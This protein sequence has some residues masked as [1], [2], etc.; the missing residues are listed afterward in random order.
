MSQVGRISGPLLQENLIR[1][2]IDLSFETDLIYLD[3]S[4]GRVGVKTN[5]PSNELQNSQTTRSTNLIV[6]TEANF[7]ILNFTN[8]TVQPFGGTN[9]IVLDARHNITAN[10]VKTDNLLIDDDRI[11][12]Y[13]T[14]TNIELRPNGTGI[15]EFNNLWV[16]NNLNVTGDVRLD[17]D[18]TFG[19]A[20]T[21]SI[22]FDADVTSN[23][24]PDADVT[25]NLGTP[26]KRWQTIEARLLNGQ[27]ID[28]QV[29]L[30]GNVNIGTRPGNLYYVST[31]GDNA[32]VGDHPQ[33]PFLTIAH[34]ASQASAGDTIHIAPGEYEE[35]CPITVP[36]GVTITGLDLR[37]T[38][39]KPTQATN[40]NNIFLLN[41][42]SSVT[43][44]TIKDFYTG[45][46]FSFAPN[47]TV[48]SRS[49]YVQNITVLTRG[50]VTSASDPRGFAQGDAGKGA[51]VDGASVLSTSKD[52]SMLFHAVTFITPG[53]DALTMTNG[54]KVEWLNSFTYF[55]NRG[56]YAV[57][58]STGHLSTDGSTVDYGA[59]IRSIGSANVYGNYGAVAD[60]SDTLMYLIQHNMAY[61]GVG[62]YSD[63]DPSRVIQSQEISK[64]NSGN[65]YYQTVNHAGNFR[66]GD[67]F[68]INQDTGESSI[69]INEGQVQG[70]GRLRAT[71]NGNVTII[72][73]EE[74]S[75]GNLLF[76]QN[77][78][79]SVIGDINVD[80]FGGDINLL[81]NT[82][83]TGDVDITG[84]LTFDGQL[85]LMGNQASDT[86]KFN[87]NFDQDI[88]PNITS[89]YD[90]GSLNK[91]WNGIWLTEAQIDDIHIEDNFITTDSSNADLDLRA[92]GTGDI[93]IPNN[94]VQVDNNL[95][96]SGDTDLQSLDVTGNIQLVGD[97]NTTGNIS[98]TNL[99]LDGNLVS[100]SQ[101]QLEEI[102]VDGNVI[103]TT[104]LNADLELRAA[105]T[106]T[107]NTSEQ[108]QINN[109]LSLSDLSAP[110]SIIT[111]TDNVRFDTAN[112]TNVV[113]QGNK[114]THKPS[115][116]NDYLRLMNVTNI[117]AD[118]IVQNNV[119][120]NGTTDIDNVTVNG[121]ITQTGNKTQT[122]NYTLAG[123]F[124]N[125]NLYI[126]DN[127]ITTTESNSDLELRANG[128]GDI[129]I[130]TD[131]TVT[132][133]NNL[134]VGGV[135]QY[136]GFLQINGDVTLQGNIQDG[137]LT[138]TE[139]FNVTGNL[140]VT[141]NAQL[142]EILIDDNFITTTTSNADLELRA[143]GTG[144][145]LF[146]E[147]TVIP[148][149]M[150]SPSMDTNNIVNSQIITSNKFSTTDNNITIDDNFITTE[151]S[152]SNL[153]L[154]A[155]GNVVSQENTIIN[156]NL[157]VNGDTDLQDTTITGT[158]TY[159]GDN[160]QT[161]NL[162]LTGDINLSGN[163][164]ITNQPFLFED[165]LI[166][167]NVLTT[168]LSNSNLSLESNGTGTVNFDSNVNVTN[169]LTARDITV[170]DIVIN[171]E[172][173]LEN[174][175]SATDVQLFDNV[176]TTS[177]SNSNL[178]LRA[179]GTGFVELQNIKFNENVIST[180]DSTI[181]LN[182]TNIDIQSNSSLQ[183]P[184]GDISQRIQR[185]ADEIIDGGDADDI[186]ITVY[187]GG[188]ATTIFGP[189]DLILD[190]GVA[191]VPSGN[192]G[193]IRYNSQLGLFEGFSQDLQYFGGV[194]SANSRTN[195][196]TTT[197]NTVEFNVNN[198]LVGTLT[199]TELSMTGLDVDAISI[200][201]NNIAISGANDLTLS[202]PGT[203]ITI[204]NGLK[205]DN[206][207]ILNES[208]TGLVIGQTGFGYTKINSTTG[209]VTPVGDE[210]NKGA[211]PQ[212]G[213][214]RW[215]TALE[216]QEVYNGTEWI[217]A[218]GIVDNV[219]ASE[220]E[221]IIDFWTLVLG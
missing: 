174:M 24:I 101:V 137:N 207:I 103:T 219:N 19:N 152:N 6:D 127:F 183:I 186:L 80:A 48:T 87:V 36:Q 79:S 50:S 38:I 218:R 135:L 66:I 167:G 121:N 191:P 209:V 171:D 178:E 62:K 69:V 184:V 2:G 100:G 111:V 195:V 188:D 77:T 112:I 102:L 99:N 141:G 98:I 12:T 5:S 35:I 214:I 23:I 44:L 196:S 96:V 138:I 55:A 199:S 25:Y 165:I 154:R 93:L 81:D 187:D 198:S 148:N 133:S 27:D 31:N 39:V 136:N 115:V 220:F 18:V 120:V 17:G 113:I 190:A 206:N 144:D 159:V 217:A 143:N 142:E 54:V 114:I 104:T 26:G 200:R 34:A 91:K 43:N 52:A 40:A 134:T 193:D 150:S 162:N 58:G 45:Y 140:D 109:N 68:F 160:N 158:I 146:T 14:D 41:G 64:L 95:T 13:T 63:N 117:S 132:I 179:A 73:G 110:N 57:N 90:L 201:N 59:E 108:V 107:I 94:N 126:E 124:S 221:E 51:L 76:N 128:T 175:V 192:L 15:T 61:V 182:T 208:A 75:T 30:I 118:T 49:P 119:I 205:F 89:S 155:T 83:V 211:T 47:A 166:D 216:I 164:S 78:I 9:N 204:P 161:G 97:K 4:S 20:D 116:G 147:N 32:N 67:N 7:P 163:F 122:G 189:N 153:E 86:L 74:V 3:V 213:E 65:I 176:I 70:F 177:N 56:L 33:G 181:I 173:A 139:D 21:D 212:Q 82:N 85:N 170:T 185:L 157:T 37:N 105:G 16:E 156:Q 131:D 42:E 71:T 210:T 215:N 180:T 60:G 22:T 92:N 125:S 53:V 149:T 129:L 29:A 202:P 106:G 84:D 123:E 168:T 203:G 46:A 151:L 72:D 11:S 8:S 1:N 172:F 130:D 145:I 197:N 10:R 88:N 28:A 169:N 194:Y